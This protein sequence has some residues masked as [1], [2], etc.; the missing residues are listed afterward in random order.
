[1]QCAKKYILQLE[2][3]LQMFRFTVQLSPVDE[4]FYNN[5]FTF[6]FIVNLDLAV[7]ECIYEFSLFENEKFQLL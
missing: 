4:A 7:G 1:M 2:V 3:R 5:V 6:H